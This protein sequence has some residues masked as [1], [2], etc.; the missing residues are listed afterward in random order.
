ML[1]EL[2]RISVSRLAWIHRIPVTTIPLWHHKRRLIDGFHT[3]VATF[4]VGTFYQ[5][6]SSSTVLIRFGLL[7][8]SVLCS[9]SVFN[10]VFVVFRFYHSV[11]NFSSTYEIW[12][13]H[14]ISTTRWVY[15]DRI[16]ICGIFMYNFYV[17]INR[18]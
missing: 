6:L 13:S 15:M 7:T 2:Y 16:W 9:V 17:I 4:S 8:L 12:I 18:F 3:T 10:R 1:I 11:V 5:K 14:M